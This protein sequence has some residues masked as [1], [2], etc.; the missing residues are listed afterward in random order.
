MFDPQTVALIRSAPELDGLDLEALPSNITS[1]YAQIVAA[2]IRAR[3]SIGR[4]SPEELQD[5][6]A[7]IVEEMRR[8]A[9]SQ[10]ALVSLTPDRDDRAAGAFVSGSAHHVVLQ[11]SS[12]LTVE[13]EASQLATDRI[14]AEISAALL[15]LAADSHADA[16]EMAKQIYVSEQTGPIEGA[17]L[18]AIKNLAKGQPGQV[19]AESEPGTELLFAVEPAQRPASA[20]FL[21]LLRGVRSLSQRLTGLT[22]SDPIEQFQRVAALSSNQL[23][24]ID[25]GGEAY[26][27]FP[28]PGHLAALLTAVGKNLPDSALVS[29][30]P[31]AGVEPGLWRTKVGEISKT[32]PFLWRNHVQAIGD[33]YLEGGISAAVSFPT[34]AGK[35]TLSELKIAACLLRLKKV[36]FLA[37]TLALVDQTARALTSLFPQAELQ[38]EQSSE[39]PSDFASSGL[40]AISVM[41]PE[42]C[43][44]VMSY[45]VESSFAEVGLL[46]FDE[47]H[48][49]HPRGSDRSRRSVDAMLCLLNFSILSP[50][51]DYLLLSAMMSNPLHLSQWISD[52]TG[53]TCLSLNLNWKPTRQVRGCVVYGAE[54]LRQLRSTLSRAKLTSSTRNPPASISRQLKAR[55]HGLFCLHQTW[56]SRQRDD[57]SLLPLLAADINLATGT[58]ASGNWYLTPNG[59]KVAAAIALG[60]AS[61]SPTGPG[62]KTL[63]FTQ[64]IPH[65]N[66]AVK[67]INESTASSLCVLNELER[68]LFESALDEL[69]SAEHLYINVSASFEVVSTSLPHH[70]LLLPVERRLHESLYQRADGVDIL[71][72]TSTV[73]QGMNLPS[74]VVIIASDSRFDPEANQMERLEAHELLN[75]A[76]RAG[77][78]GESSHGFVLVVPSKVMDFDDSSSSIHS[79]WSEL[80]SIFSQSDQ[81]LAIEDPLAPILDAIHIAGSANSDAEKYLLRRLPVLSSEGSGDDPAGE[82]L[83]RSMGA[84]F[85]RREGDHE[86]VASRISSAL[87]A[88]RRTSEDSPHPD[89]MDQLAASAGIERSVVQSLQSRMESSAPAD[90]ASVRTWISFMFEW[91]QS[92]C[93]V[94]TQLLRPQSLENFFGR[95]YRSLTS[96]EARCRWSVPRL[97]ALLELWIEGRTL[98]DIE[99]AVLTPTSSMGNCVNAREFVL[100]MVPELAYAFTLPELIAEAEKRFE[101]D[102]GMSPA[103]RATLGACVREGFDSPDKLALQLETPGKAPRRRIH[104]SWSD[105][106]WLVGSTEAVETWPA[107]RAKIRL[108]LQFGSLTA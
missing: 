82:L 31:P 70:G 5:S 85:K 83:K 1:A 47:C 19:L 68:N 101:G 6:V 38:K 55:P 100:R 107:V 56:Q 34:G 90:N 61:R 37:P 97:K 54:E 49:L 15:F 57:Y 102:D 7:A 23:S 27:V 80:Q 21:M 10:E 106:E 94:M 52:L 58:S 73:A 105:L 22:A 77:R 20:L 25:L 17:L 66:S 4:D 67:N 88:R 39:G 86:W 35:S 75:A 18:N 44:A 95:P 60:A 28:G 51:A 84:Y 92:D 48:L 81:C 65:A 43:L 96:D 87:E 63:V 42:R 8:I 30:P 9:F 69:G 64:T 91:M 93:D 36:I 53:R 89:W 72:A 24:D 71:V 14:S 40:P 16:A 78:A 29:L 99:R 62:L 79:H 32:R 103:A 41:T 98:A 12:L 13:R 3:A 2:R 108:A 76:G 50:N 74:Q 45:G 11:A 104:R 46:V 26:S 33:G 59:I